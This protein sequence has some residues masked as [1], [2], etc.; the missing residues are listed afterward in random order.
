MWKSHLDIAVVVAS[1]T[2]VTRVHQHSIEAVHNRV[3]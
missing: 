2:T 1:V 3:A